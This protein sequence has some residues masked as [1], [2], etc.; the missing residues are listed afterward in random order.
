MEEL[1]TSGETVAD[2][3]LKEYGNPDDFC[4]TPEEKGIFINLVTSLK[5]KKENL[6]K[7]KE[8][9][10][11]KTKKVEEL[12]KKL[13]GGKAEEVEIPPVAEIVIPVE[14]TDT[15]NLGPKEIEVEKIDSKEA[16]DTGK[17]EKAI[18]N[19]ETETSTTN[20]NQG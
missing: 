10:I 9:A 14:E 8:D 19:Q 12:E 17:V 13:T 18:E 4:D 7:L 6:I 5:N 1:N 3:I 15:G 11:L 20:K 16:V 2:W